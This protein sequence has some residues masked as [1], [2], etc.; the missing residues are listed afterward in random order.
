MLIEKEIEMY[1]E[2]FNNR[3]YREF[4]FNFNNIIPLEKQ[5]LKVIEEYKD[6]FEKEQVIDYV[7]SI[8]INFIMENK[9]NES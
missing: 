8:H 9:T 4:V 3:G 7:V 1:K 2:N 5:L 6:I